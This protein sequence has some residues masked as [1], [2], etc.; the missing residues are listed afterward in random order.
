MKITDLKRYV[1]L[2]A[3]PLAISEGEVPEEFLVFAYGKTKFSKEGKEDFYVFSEND[4]D[5]V[6]AEFARKGVDGLVDYE[7]QLLRSMSNGQPVPAGG[8]IK[9]LVKKPDG[10]WC[11]VSWTPKARGYLENGEYKYTSPVFRVSRTGKNITDLFNIS[12]TGK[13][14]TDNQP[15]LVAAD[16]FTEGLYGDL[17]NPNNKKGNGNMNKL[18]IM[19]GL[20]TL[21]DSDDEAAIESGVETAVQELLDGKK[22]TAD[23]L[24]LHDADGFD[25]LTTKIKD[26]KKE[27]TDFLALHDA[28][29]LVAFSKKLK[30]KDAEAAV[31]DAIARRKLTEAKK[32]DGLALALSDM[33]MFKR[34]YDDKAPDVVPDNKGLDGLGDQN[35]GKGGDDGDSELKALSDAELTVLNNCGLSGDNLKKAAAELAKLKKGE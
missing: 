4:A 21:A 8:W 25:A 27:V 9:Q 18:L 23:F 11:R 30:Q 16:D 22:K 6:I 33:D 2:S 14:S 26:G 10:L 17:I 5:T 1:I 7:H 28:E 35:K 19:L 3:A 20:K 24:A 29:S 12:L 34:T 32:E 13:P 31:Q 15:A